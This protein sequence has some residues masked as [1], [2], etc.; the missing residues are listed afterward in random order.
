MLR[1]DRIASDSVLRGEFDG[2]RLEGEGSAQVGFVKQLR[3]GPME[4]LPSRAAFRKARL[5][6]DGEEVLRE[7]ELE[8]TFAIA[9]HRREEAPGLRKLPQDRCAAETARH[10][11]RHRRDPGAGRRH[12]RAGAR[13]RVRRTSI[14]DSPKARSTP[15]SRLQWSMPIGGSDASGASRTDALGVAL[16]VD[17]QDIAL[18]VKA[19]PLAQ[20]RMSVDADLRLR[21]RG[22]P[23]G[24]FPSL[25]PRAS[26]HVVGRWRFSSLHWITTCFRG[27]RG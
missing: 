7:A 22:I 3:G 25:L 1:F 15:G 8:A 18:K 27:R 20:G 17:R 11:Q 14:S 12:P 9:R 13:A 4:L 21:G 5:A 2:L 19:P 6:R 16:A 26:G 23:L 24:D 10:H